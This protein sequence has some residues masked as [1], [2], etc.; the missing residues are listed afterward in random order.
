ML[1]GGETLDR[2]SLGAAEGTLDN[3]DALR[4]DHPGVPSQI[5][6]TKKTT[7]TNRFY[8]SIYEWR[9]KWGRTFQ[10]QTQR[11]S[12]ACHEDLMS[13]GAALQAGTSL[14]ISRLDWNWEVRKQGEINSQVE[15]NSKQ[16]DWELN[17]WSRSPAASLAA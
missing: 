12:R 1:P 17:L 16:K 5:W 3:G 10:T 7:Q 13:R 2:A 4:M 11:R 8:S 9:Q 6:W 15:G 14:P